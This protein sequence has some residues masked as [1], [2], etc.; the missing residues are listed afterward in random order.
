VEE[1]KQKLILKLQTRVEAA[2]KAYSADPFVVDYATRHIFLVPL[3][4]R[5]RQDLDSLRC[6]LN[7][8]DLA[9]DRQ[10]LLHAI[11]ATS[12]AQFFFPKSLPRVISCSALTNTSSFSSLSGQSA[13]KL[14]SFKE[15]GR[16]EVYTSLES[17]ITGST[18]CSISTVTY[19][20]L[21]ETVTSEAT[22]LESRSS[23]SGSVS[24]I[25]K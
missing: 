7:S 20:E 5:L 9:I 11:R 25:T 24:T 12:A 8:Y 15:N 1:S 17:L 14:E 23:S 6:F 10:G 3:P 4:V 2:Y 21:S 16:S 18:A 19:P 22:D 13:R